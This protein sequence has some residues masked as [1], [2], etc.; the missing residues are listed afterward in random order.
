MAERGFGKAETQVRFL[1]LAPVSVI[2]LIYK[3]TNLA[4]GKIYVGKTS[5]S[6]CKRWQRH[7]RNVNEGSQ[8]HFHRAI[9]KYGPES[10]Q[11]VVIISGCSDKDRLNRLERYWIKKLRTSDPECG[12]NMTDGG[13]GISGYRFTSEIRKKIGAKV[14]K[15]LMGDKNSVGRRHSVETRHKM[16]IA[17]RARWARPGERLN[18]SISMKRRWHAAI[19]KNIPV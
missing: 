3:I 4:N 8:T 5:L 14:S 16:R 2:M 6:C 10:F 18:L 19:V 12:Y 9:R 11:A 17:Q 1:P 7:I 15:A 13:E